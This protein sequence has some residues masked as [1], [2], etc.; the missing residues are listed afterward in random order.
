MIKI[1][2]NIILLG[3]SHVSK[4]STLQIKQ[5]IE[6]YNPEV[7]GIELDYSRFKSLMSKSKHKNNP[8][9]TY[10]VKQFGLTGAIF[11]VVA[12]HFQK[13][14]GKKMKIEPGIDMKTAYTESRKHKIPTSLIDLNI[15]KTMRKISN[16]STFKKIRLFFK[17]IFTSL[18]PKNA[19]KY[20]FDINK[21]VPSEK[22]ILQIFDFLKGEFPQIY[23]ILIEDRNKFMVK[24]LLSLRERHKEGYILA[25]VG[26]GHVPG[27]Y[28]L[29]EKEIKEN[30]HTTVDRTITVTYKKF[31]NK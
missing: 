19:K 17:L 31:N 16:I 8:K 4:Q 29:L 2:D 7:V 22:T 30:S 5:V 10:L 14:I 12:G 9:F 26:A 25:V 18:N 23:N 28:D 13:K 24:K 15:K 27:M 11:T 6:K 21:G 20:Q 3:T 1:R